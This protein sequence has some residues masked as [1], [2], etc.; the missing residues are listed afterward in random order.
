TK[1]R[2]NFRT[3]M[4]SKLSKAEKEKDQDDF[5]GGDPFFKSSKITTSKPQMQIPNPLF[6]V[7]I[8]TQLLQATQATTRSSTSSPATTL[9]SVNIDQ[10]S[11]NVNSE[12]SNRIPTS[13]RIKTTSTISKTSKL[14]ITNFNVQNMNKYGFKYQ[15]EDITPVRT[16]NLDVLNNMFHSNPFTPIPPIPKLNRGNPFFAQQIV[17]PWTP[18]WPFTQQQTPYAH[19]NSPYD[20]FT[21]H[22]WNNKHP[23]GRADKFFL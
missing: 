14:P 18:T 9:S 15:N 7:V 13:N 12:N 19:P 6:D 20:Y 17:T 10:T 16:E 2:F 5:F 22:M 4:D 11:S 8:P 21:P 1:V 23:D 3:K